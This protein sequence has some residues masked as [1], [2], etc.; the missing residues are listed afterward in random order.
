[1]W[2]PCVHVQRCGFQQASF[3]ERVVAFACVEG[4]FFSGSFCAIFWMKKRGKVR[5]VVAV[6]MVVACWC[7][8]VAGTRSV[9]SILLQSSSPI[10]FD[11]G[12]RGSFVCWV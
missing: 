10:L 9:G 8:L 4:I 7:H 3:A 6:F 11:S 5:A 12:L 1:M 2:D